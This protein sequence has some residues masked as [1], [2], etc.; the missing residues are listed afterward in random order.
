V[1]SIACGSPL[2][3]RLVPLLKGNRF[4]TKSRKFL[5]DARKGDLSW[6]K[7]EVEERRVE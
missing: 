1:R 5:I 2:P 6:V 3:E 7:K 4:L